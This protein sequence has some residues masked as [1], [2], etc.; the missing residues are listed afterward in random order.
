MRGK[1]NTLFPGTLRVAEEPGKE[2]RSQ[3]AAVTA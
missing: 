3:A 1:P 2:W